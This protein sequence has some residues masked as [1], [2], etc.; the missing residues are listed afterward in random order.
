[1]ATAIVCVDDIVDAYLL[2]R[3]RDIR[4]GRSVDILVFVLSMIEFDCR[5]AFAD[6]LA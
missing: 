6:V 5:L 4:L 3:T 1:M 2:V